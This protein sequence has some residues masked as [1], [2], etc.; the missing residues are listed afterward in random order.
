MPDL[1]SF[2]ADWTS[3]VMATSTPGKGEREIETGRQGER[4]DL[5]SLL[6]PRGKAIYTEF[7]SKPELHLTGRIKPPIR[8]RDS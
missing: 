6:S 5:V 3:G 8:S 2:S 4:T 1:F 7:F